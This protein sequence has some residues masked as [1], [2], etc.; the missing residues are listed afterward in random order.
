MHCILFYGNDHAQGISKYAGPARLATEL[1]INGFET[2]CIDIGTI[3]HIS[4]L[5]LYEKIINKFVSK[6]TLWIGFSTTFFESLCGVPIKRITD[7]NQLVTSNNDVGFLNKIIDMCKAKNPT[8]KFIVGG[9][10]YINL[11]AYNFI[12][13]RGN[14][15]FEIVEFTK[16]CKDSSYSPKLNHS[17][18]IVTCKE[19]DKFVISKIKWDKTDLLSPSTVLPIEISRGCIFKCKFCAFPLNG[20]TKGEWVKHAE[21]LKEELIENYENFGTTEYIFADDTYNDSMDKITDLY[22][23]VFSQLPF[24]IKWTAY[25]RLDLMHRFKESADILYKSGIKNIMVG[26]ETNNDIS[27]KAIG[28]GLDFNKQISYIQDLKSKDYKDILIS[29]GFIYGLPNDTR[30]SIDG[31]HNWLLSKDNPLDNWAV[32][33]LGINPPDKTF[34]KN[35]FSDIDINYEKYG[36]VIP[37][38]LKANKQM[39]WQLPNQNLSFEQC[40]ILSNNTLEKSIAL[41]NYKAGSFVYPRFRSMGI[42]E[43]E[44]ISKSITNLR[45][46]YNV[47]QII[48]K[49]RLDYFAS[50]LEI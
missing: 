34:N 23:N 47:E 31:L 46:K 13:F 4:F 17:N 45:K 35:N 44:L 15:D 41:P 18:K 27:A 1:R 30:D 21:I 36:Y 29:S 19:Y 32:T 9:G 20:K 3:Q 40:S 28:K 10:N 6:D 42:S 12:H 50:L 49:W 38:E 48:K 5:D 2:I 14:A 16:W 22:E 24:K 33:T 37:D 43:E 11:H 26:I 39:S 25:L 7:Q 8:I